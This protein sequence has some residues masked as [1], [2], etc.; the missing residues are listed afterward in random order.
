MLFEKY[1]TFF[2]TPGEKEDWSKLMEIMTPHNLSECGVMDY[3]ELAKC[4]GE[5]V[6]RQYQVYHSRFQQFLK[7]SISIIQL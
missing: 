5:D 1:L 2:F 4:L 6:S 7:L 3:S